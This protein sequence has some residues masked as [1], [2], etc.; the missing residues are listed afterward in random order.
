MFLFRDFRWHIL[1][2]RSPSP[3]M[4]LRLKCGNLTRLRQC[5]A[6][7]SCAALC[8]YVTSHNKRYLM[9]IL[10]ILRFFAESKRVSNRLSDDTILMK[11]WLWLLKIWEK[12]GVYFLL[13]SLYFTSYFAQYL[14]ISLTW[15]PLLSCVTYFHTWKN[16][17]TGITLFMP[18]K[19]YK[20]NQNYEVDLPDPP[21]NMTLSAFIIPA[22]FTR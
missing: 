14:Q 22:E 19:M 16:T 5:M 8:V 12:D 7:N 15:Y 2:V 3:Y 10:T 13:F 21:I 20:K 6:M 18:S 17:A 4:P 1:L 9:S 11:I